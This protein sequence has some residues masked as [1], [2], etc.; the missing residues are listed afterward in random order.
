VSEGPSRNSLRAD[1]ALSR[2]SLSSEAR[3]DAIA[4]GATS[5]RAVSCHLVSPRAVP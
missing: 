4:L 1:A 2:L 5:V 3:L